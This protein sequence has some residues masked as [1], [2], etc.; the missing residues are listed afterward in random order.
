MRDQACIAIN[1][2][3]DSGCHFEVQQCRQKITSGGR[4]FKSVT[5]VSLSLH[6]YISSMSSRRSREDDRDDSHRRSKKHSRRDR[7]SH[8]D[9]EDH[10]VKKARSM[11]KGM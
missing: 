6:T 2:T 5:P 10:L 8:S 3:W 9:D 7:N 1:L 11:I 4:A